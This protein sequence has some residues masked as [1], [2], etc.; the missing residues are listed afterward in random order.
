MRNKVLEFGGRAFAFL[1]PQHNFILDV[2]WEREITIFSSCNHNSLFFTIDR[3]M[4]FVF[5]RGKA[6]GLSRQPIDLPNPFFK[7]NLAIP[8]RNIK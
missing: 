2:A 3:S 8:F 4:S 5:L 6:N 7:E 1:F